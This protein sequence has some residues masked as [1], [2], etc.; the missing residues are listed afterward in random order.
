[1]TVIGDVMFEIVGVTVVISEVMERTVGGLF[2]TV[3]VMVLED[4]IMLEGLVVAVI[5]DFGD[6]DTELDTGVVIAIV[7]CV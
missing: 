6:T 7:S 5:G 3:V 2:V 4:E 1:M